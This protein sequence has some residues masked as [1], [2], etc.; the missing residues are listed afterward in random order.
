MDAID[1]ELDVDVAVSFDELVHHL[2]ELPHK[3]DRFIDAGVIV[4]ND[5]GRFDLLQATQAYL[6]YWTQIIAKRASRRR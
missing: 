5:D 1:A 2:G 6:G 3:L 4:P